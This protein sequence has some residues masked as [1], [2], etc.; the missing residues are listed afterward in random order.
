[1]TYNTEKPQ[2]PEFLSLAHATV[3]L[4]YVVPE[5]IGLHYQTDADV[6]LRRVQ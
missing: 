6:G 5:P 1:M 2:I 4:V 3:V